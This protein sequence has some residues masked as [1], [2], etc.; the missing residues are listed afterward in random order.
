MLCFT[1]DGVYSQSESFQC[2]P[3]A[4]HGFGILDSGYPHSCWAAELIF[5]KQNWGHNLGWQRPPRWCGSSLP[6]WQDE[7]A[8]H[9]APQAEWEWWVP[10]PQSCVCHSWMQCQW[11][12]GS[13]QRNVQIFQ[14]EGTPSPLWDWAAAVPQSPGL[15]PSWHL[16]QALP[17]KPQSWALY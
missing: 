10:N 13:A 11:K 14:G 17:A 15:F 1:L 3:S 4:V 8:E 7:W 9:P 5:P 6:W 16:Q 2:S 12:Q